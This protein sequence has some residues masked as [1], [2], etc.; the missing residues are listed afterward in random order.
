M[1]R[2]KST[3]P[4]PMATARMRFLVIGTL[5][6]APPDPGELSK[7]IGALAARSW[8]SPTNPK[9]QVQFASSTIERWYYQARKADDPVAVLARRTRA[10]AGKERATC[11]ALIEE[12]ARQYGAHGNW[13]FRL[14]HDNLV[15]IAQGDRVKFGDPPSYPTMRRLMQRRGWLRRRLPRNPTAG[16]ERALERLEHREVRSFESPFVH[17]LWHLDFHDG[18]RR[19]IDEKGVWHTPQCLCILDDRSRLCCHIQWFLNEDTRCLVHGLHQA[20]CKRGIPRSLMMDNGP[21]MI[22]A[23]T[24]EGLARCGISEENILPYSPYQNGKQESFWGSLEGRLLA[25]MDRVDPLTLDFL[26]LATQAWIEGEYNH[27]LHEEMKVTPVERM[28][29][30]PDVARRAPDLETLRRRF[31]RCETR[32]QRRSDGTLQVGGLRFEM[33]SRLRTLR[34][35]CVRW[36]AWDLSEAWLVDKDDALLATI[37]PLDRVKNGQ[38][39]RRAFVAT[40]NLAPRPGPD[41][42]PI[43]P[44][45]QKLLAEHAATGLPPAYLPLDT[46][47]LD[48]HDD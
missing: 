46:L 21:A 25:M 8:P 41:T 47:P 4:L 16:Q 39:G 6:A 11:P 22:A 44:L 18:S 20:F 30:G 24:R 19:V 29:A 1:K 15:V 17:G 31:T 40:P 10:D 3:H 43:P 2:D 34:T 32:V 42:N 37:Q 23:E 5:L 48:N 33:P 13:S 36:R 38:S 7:A 14:H 45:L 9:E 28:L 12:L 26:N 35:V 27:H